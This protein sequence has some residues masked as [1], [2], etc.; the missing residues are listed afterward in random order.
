MEVLY[1]KKTSRILSGHLWVFKQEIDSS[2]KNYKP[3]SIVELRDRKEQFLGIGYINPYSN[4]AVRVL[5]RRKE[6]INSIFFE[7]RIREAISYRERFLPDTESC[8]LIYSESDL[9]SG[10]IVDK[11]SDWLVIQS[12]T[13][14]MDRFLP[15]IIEILDTLIKP[16][17]IFVKNDAPSRVLEGLE[18]KTEFL[19]GT[20][21]SFPVIRE[22][23]ILLKIDPVHGQKTGFF[24]DQ[25]ENRLALSDFI[26]GGKGLDLFC[27]TGA[28]GLQLAKNGAHVLFIDDSERALSL[29][30]ENAEL[31][32]LSERCTFLKADVFDFLSKHSDEK[33]DF[34]VLDPPAF[35]KTKT[36]IEEALKGYRFINSTCM[37]LLKK[38]GILATSSCSHHISRE[39]FFDLLRQAARGAGRTIRL[40]EFRSQAKD[41]P[42]LLHVPETEYLK[43]AILQVL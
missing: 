15:Q 30:K 14:G 35:V 42:V 25:R 27:Y 4:I 40:I 12:L 13:A 6:K 43:C 28:W 16:S 5:T 7:K 20:G 29:A 18:L 19:K 34:I 33:F 17:T 3:G 8:R 22:G 38:D 39:L 10:L 31:N 1:L 23:H 41:H 32:G 37:R 26:K 9:L 24:L 36:K 11:Y 21:E 2:I